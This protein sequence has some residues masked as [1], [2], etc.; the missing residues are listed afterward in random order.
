MDHAQGPDAMGIAYRCSAC[1]GWHPARVRAATES[2]FAGMNEALGPT[3]E[4]CP[5]TGAWVRCAPADRRWSG[6]ERD[7]RHASPGRDA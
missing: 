4:P 5:G 3:L 1:G 2:F 6:A 7:A